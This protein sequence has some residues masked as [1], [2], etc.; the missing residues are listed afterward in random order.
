MQKSV[1][2]KH[3]DSVNGGVEAGVEFEMKVTDVFKNDPLGRQCMEGVR[4]REAQCDH[5]L[6]SKE[7]FRQ[8]GELIAELPG[9]DN[10]ETTTRSTTARTTTTT[11]STTTTT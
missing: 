10:K 4:I 2:R 7:E 11:T 5:C 8:P 6:N 9:S 3:A 1:L